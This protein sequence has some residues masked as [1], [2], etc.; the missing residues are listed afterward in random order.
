MNPIEVRNIGKRFY[1]RRERV[2][3][4]KSA[5]VDILRLKREVKKIEF[6]ALR[7]LSFSVEKGKT[8]GIIG[9][10]GA[11]KSTLL[12]LIANTMLPTEGEIKVAGRVSSLLELGAGFH[13]DLTGRENIFLNGSI[14]GLK[15]FEIE[16]KFKQ[17]VSFS[18]LESF[19]DVPVKHYSSGMYV[20]LGF[21]IAVEV[22]PDILLIDEV[23]AVGDETFR[24]KCL[25]KIVDFQK[26]RKTMLIVSHDLDT[27]KK[28]CDRIMLI[29]EGKFI[30]MG[31]P[32]EVVEKYRELGLHKQAGILVKEWGTREIEIGQVKFLDAGGKGTQ[33]FLTGDR[34]T[35][36][37]PF[38]AREKI[39]RPCFG[40]SVTDREGRICFGTNTLI[41]KYSVPFV[42]GKGVINL[43]I[44]SIPLFHGKYFFSLAVHSEDHQ[45][46]YH[47]QDNQYVIWVESEK[48]AEGFVDMKCRWEMVKE[49]KKIKN[50]QQGNLG[51]DI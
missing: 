45:K 48:K 39:A 36:Q 50:F 29:D 14:L 4:F 37:I 26:D 31:E 47:R 20:R 49:V 13:P 1:P 21:S 3:T 19:I 12:G 9:A 34:I 44:D 30:D 17:I 10:N 41:E 51:L 40:F 25:N 11:G 22:N 5:V 28:I 2:R 38:C 6:W 43:T 27:L 32:L 35:V 42:Q 46:H 16:K 33:H 15:R 18:E 24:K 7:K 23:L 8:L